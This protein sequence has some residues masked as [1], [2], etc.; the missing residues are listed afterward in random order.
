MHPAKYQLYRYYTELNVH[1][2]GI[3]ISEYF[4]KY[5]DRFFFPSHSRLMKKRTV[6]SMNL[7]SIGQVSLCLKA[8]EIGEIGDQAVIFFFFFCPFDE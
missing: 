8:A 6:I 7:F 3:R 5:E 1:I 4:K 2:H